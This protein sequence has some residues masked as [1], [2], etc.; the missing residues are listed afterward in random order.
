MRPVAVDQF[1]VGKAHNF[2]RVVA[3]AS[4]GLATT[5][6]TRSTKM[7]TPR[8]KVLVKFAWVFWGKGSTTLGLRQMGSFGLLKGESVGLSVSKLSIECQ[9]HAGSYR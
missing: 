4:I 3:W 1:C 5:A 6:R 7:S 9:H 2:N 8:E